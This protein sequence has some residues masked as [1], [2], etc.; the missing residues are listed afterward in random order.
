MNFRSFVGSPVPPVAMMVLTGSKP[1]TRTNAEALHQLDNHVI[2][3]VSLSRLR[4][5]FDA[6]FP[7]R[8]VKRPKKGGERKPPIPTLTDPIAQLVVM[9]RS[10][11]LEPDDI[12]NRTTPSCY[13]DLGLPDHRWTEATTCSRSS[14]WTTSL[15]CTLFPSFRVLQQLNALLFL[16]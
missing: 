12:G 10:E 14:A 6:D 3:Q 9:A 5:A 1:G 4:A 13:P 2:A 16:V 11:L 15:L 8:S 7:G